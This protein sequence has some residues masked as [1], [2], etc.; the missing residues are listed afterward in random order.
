MKKYGVLFV[1][2]CLVLTSVWAQCDGRYQTEIFDELTVTEVEYTDVYDW[3]IVNS[4]LDMDVYEPA[5][6]TETN[7]PLIVFVHGGS[8]YA[9]DKNNPPVVALCE[10]FARR[11]YVTAS[12]QYRLTTMLQLTDSLHMLETVMNAIG[13]AKAAIRYFRKDVAENGNAFGIDPDQIYMGGYSAGAIIAVNL[14]FIDNEAELPDYLLSIVE[15]AGG[16]EGSSGNPGYSSEVKG[17]AS[18]AGAVYLPSFIDANDEPIV[19]VHAED[20]ATVQYACGAA[21]SID[22]MVG[23]CGSGVVHEVAETQGVYNALHTF[24]SGGHT[25]P[26]TSIQEVSIP[27]ISDFLYTTLDCYEGETSVEAPRLSFSVYPNPAKGGVKVVSEDLVKSIQLFDMKGR[28]VFEKELD[29]KQCSL[30]FP[31]VSSGLYVL[32]LETDKG[33]SSIRLQLQ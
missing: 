16:L 5:E 28:I 26:Y 17:V 4:G 19:S 30:S 12:I 1:F 23:L 24:S 11:G 20:D 13:D 15:G 18:L 2:L 14:A 32:Q 25:A 10:A 27:F 6:D 29:A 31:S 3:S 8:F 9:G 22:G 21:L 7:R 33:L